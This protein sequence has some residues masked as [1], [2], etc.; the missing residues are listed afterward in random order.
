MR[1]PGHD[2]GPLAGGRGYRALPKRRRSAIARPSGR[3][4][5]GG[6]AKLLRELGCPPALCEMRS[7]KV[8]QYA[9]T[10]VGDM[11]IDDSHRRNRSH[12]ESAIA[13]DGTGSSTLRRCYR[14]KRSTR[15]RCA[16]VTSL[17]Q[18]ISS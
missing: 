11:D 4:R 1:W 9:L 5:V 8:L 16:I 13:E 17:S 3:M 2:H 15:V 10:I 6:L 14:V 12:Y 7:V 18:P